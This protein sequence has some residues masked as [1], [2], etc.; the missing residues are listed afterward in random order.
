M[1][2]RLMVL[3]AD[4]V[5]RM[6]MQFIGIAHP[7]EQLSAR[8][9]ETVR[10]MSEAELKTA[11]GILEKAGRARLH[12]QDQ[13]EWSVIEEMEV[14]ENIETRKRGARRPR[15]SLRTTRRSG[16]D[17]STGRSATAARP[18]RRSE[19]RRWGR[20]Y[21]GCFFDALTGAILRSG[22]P[23]SNGW[24]TRTRTCGYPRHRAS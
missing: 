19:R 6:T 24:P 18:S 13:E 16:R 22:A 12:D 1:V 4:A 3:M 9:V 2:L 21:T 14:E 23:F 15:R 17:S 8:L 20:T 7:Q 11:K 10:D 5:Q